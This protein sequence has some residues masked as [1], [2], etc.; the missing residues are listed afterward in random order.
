MKTHLNIVLVISLLI[1]CP[2]LLVA[3]DQMPLSGESDEATK[4][5]REAMECRANAEIDKCEKLVDQAL[6]ADPNNLMA[7]FM[8]M[9]LDSNYAVQ[10]KGRLDDLMDQGNDDEKTLI[11]LW[12]NTNEE[13]WG[14]TRGATVNVKEDID[15]LSNKYEKD[16]Y[17][18]LQL[19]MIAMNND[20]KDKCKSILESITERDKEFA[21]AH[22]LL[23]YVFMDEGKMDKAEEHFDKYIELAPDKANPYDSKGDYYMEQKDYKKACEMY[24]K[25][26]KMDPTMD[27]SKE[28]AEKAKMQMEEDKK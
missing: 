1:L 23:G 8:K 17:L 25:A 12:R 13:K 5:V 21:P 24:E 22:N 14:K 3:Q 20:Q 9:S 10:N 2:L 4:L 15:N 27:W 18:Q 16:N 11:S 7:N 28:K 6:E 19:A 26:Y